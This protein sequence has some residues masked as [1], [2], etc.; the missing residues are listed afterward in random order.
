MQSVKT[1]VPFPVLGKKKRKEKRGQAEK[2]ARPHI[3][4]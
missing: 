4:Q 3:K 1:G 2:L